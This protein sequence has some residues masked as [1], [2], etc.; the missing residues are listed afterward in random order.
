MVFTDKKLNDWMF[1]VPIYP[2]TIESV[3]TICQENSE[4]VDLENIKLNRI[5]N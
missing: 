4:V 3:Y 5:I 2:F 1:I